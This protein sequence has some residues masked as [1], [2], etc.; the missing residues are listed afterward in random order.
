MFAFCATGF[1][2]WAFGLKRRVKTLE[3]MASANNVNQV[4]GS[5][6]PPQFV[7]EADTIAMGQ[8]VAPDAD[9]KGNPEFSIA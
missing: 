1:A 3:N 9:G 4:I 7:M 2:M 8:P 6:A 5:P